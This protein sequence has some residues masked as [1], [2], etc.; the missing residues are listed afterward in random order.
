[1][2]INESEKLME[3]SDFL[4][5]I[6]EKAAVYAG[7]EGTADITHIIK[8]NGL[9]YDG[10]VIMQKGSNISPTIYL[11]DYYKRYTKG[12][13]LE[14][15]FRSV[16][17]LY[18]KGKNQKTFDTDIFKTFNGVKKKIAFKLINYE[19]NLKL[20]EKIPH[21]RIMNLA[22]VFYCLVEKG[23]CGNATALIYNNNMKSWNIG[24]EELYE[25]AMENTPKILQSNLS[26]MYSILDSFIQQGMLDAP[27]ITE[28][29]CGTRNMYILTN[30][31]KLNGAACILYPGVLEEF[32]DS[33]RSDLY[34]IPSSIHEVILIPKDGAM[35]KNSLTNMVRE[36]NAEGVPRDEVLS[37]V[38]Y[39]YSR[40][41]QQITL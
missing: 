39:E 21:K 17:D 2:K 3:Y 15:L 37:D 23:E 40:K 13:K 35:D 20:L 26:S 32:A 33:I 1:M 29:E 9:E 28:A 38:V 30:E 11:N 5:Y 24:I 36:V 18:E 19:Y 10:L 41:T 34:I 8:N 4:N 31:C 7:E 12:E 6:K 25:A 14:E 16:I 22:M 27:D